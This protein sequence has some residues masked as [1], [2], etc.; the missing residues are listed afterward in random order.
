ML[1]LFFTGSKRRI[2]WSEASTLKYK[3]ARWSHFPTEITKFLCLRHTKQVDELKLKTAAPPFSSMKPHSRNALC[4]RHHVLPQGGVWQSDLIPGVHAL[5]PLIFLLCLFASASG[6]LSS[7]HPSAGLLNPQLRLGSTS[8]IVCIF[9]PKVR[10]VQPHSH[11]ASCSSAE[12]RSGG[13]SHLQT[14]CYSLFVSREP[15]WADWI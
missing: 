3:T 6:L 10:S 4:C 11:L 15:Y 12:C 8:S 5:C 9:H 1:L 13:T 14:N 2:R 7:I